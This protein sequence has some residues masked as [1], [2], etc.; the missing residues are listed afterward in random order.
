MKNLDNK[1]AV[2]PSPALTCYAVRETPHNLS[3]EP[4]YPNCDTVIFSIRAPDWTA[5]KRGD[6]CQIEQPHLISD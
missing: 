1:A 2:S 5:H 6:N 4:P 3:A